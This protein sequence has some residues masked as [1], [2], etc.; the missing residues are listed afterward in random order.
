VVVNEVYVERLSGRR[1]HEGI[2]PDETIGRRM[3]LVGMLENANPFRIAPI[4]IGQRHWKTVRIVH[5][6]KS[7]RVEA[8]VA[9]QVEV[10]AEVGRAGREIRDH[11][12]GRTRVV[13]EVALVLAYIGVVVQRLAIGVGVADVGQVDLVLPDEA[14]RVDIIRRY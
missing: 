14:L 12:N 13:E 6:L 5:A 4:K 1:H 11:K 9:I 8:S 10:K 7:V 3:R 2:T